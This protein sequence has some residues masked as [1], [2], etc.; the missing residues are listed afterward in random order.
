VY[1]KLVLRSTT[2]V[3]GCNLYIAGNQ[4][5]FV[6]CT[7]VLFFCLFIVVV[8]VFMSFLPTNHAAFVASQYKA[9]QRSHPP[10]KREYHEQPFAPAGSY[11]PLD[12]PPLRLIMSTVAC[13]DGVMFARRSHN[14]C[15]KVAY[16]IFRPNALNSQYRHSPLVVIHGGPS[17]PCDYLL[18]LVD[19]IKMPPRSIIFF[20]QLGCGRSDHPSSLDDYSIDYIVQD[21]HQLINET[22]HLSK[23]HLYG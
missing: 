2:G 11:P 13:R 3:R 8:K 15:Y 14:N 6:G 4:F 20:D 1:R 19:A 9:E 16:R 22:L 5:S 21:L 17:V 7:R 10:T 18:P 23:F 12:P